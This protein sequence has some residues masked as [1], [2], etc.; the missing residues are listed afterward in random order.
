MSIRLRLALW[1]GLLCA[2]L[3]VAVSFLAYA[4]Y[5]RDQYRVLDRV[6]VLSAN[7]AAAGV[8]A[9]GRSYVFG[10]ERSSLDVVLRLYGPD[11]QLRQASPNG[12]DL[13][14]TRPRD[15]LDS[16]AGP[17]YA[18]LAR[19]LPSFSRE[20]A[21][22]PNAAFGIITIRGERW[23]RYVVE[24]FQG[25]RPLAFVEAIT[26]LGGLDAAVGLLARVLLLLDLV[27]AGLAFALGWAVAGSALAPITQLTAVARGIKRS[28]DLARRVP[29]P[30]QR[31]E[32]GRLAETFNDMLASLEGASLTQQRFIA[33]ASHELRAPLT[34]MQGNLEL[35][36]RFPNMS[37]EDRAE[38]LAE[39][40]REAARLGRLVGDLLTLARGDA[41]VPLLA[42]RLRFDELTAS[43]LRDWQRAHG[44]HV[45]RDDGLEETPVRGD[46]DRL[47]QVLLNL[48]DNA[49]KFGPGGQTVTVRVARAAGVVQV[50]VEDEGA[51]VPP[52][53]RDRVWEPFF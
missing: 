40:E 42:E 41:G 33:D 29:E 50:S 17:A 9:S 26:P 18:P 19:L 37:P 22:P 35:L 52:A 11:S 21:P 36:R 16:P 6:L 30:R 53:E 39:A 10:A 49:V 13:P 23:R 43:V 1:Y 20:P 48:L 8:R 4:M 25:G 31:D 32:V 24:L 34:A 46:P 12:S 28:R 5:A 51:G 2:A 38:A 44:S 47:R 45:V 27:F 3:L 14:A 7:N 15:A